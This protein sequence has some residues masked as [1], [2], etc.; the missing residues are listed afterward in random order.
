MI[1]TIN[2]YPVGGHYPKVDWGGGNFPS[3]VAVTRAS[4]G[5]AGSAGMHA[6]VPVDGSVLPKRIVWAEAVDNPPPDFDEMPV[7]NISGRARAVMEEIE[8]DT[9]Q[10]FPVDYVWP[11]GTQIETRYWLI[12]CN[13]LNAIDPLRSNLVMNQYNWYIPPKDAVRRKVPMPAHVDPAL[14]PKIVI[15]KSKADGRHFWREKHTDSGMALMSD[16]AWKAIQD[17]GLTGLRPQ[18]LEVS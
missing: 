3:P 4:D 6:G 10:F 1:Y 13:R 8:P 12:I 17:A 15:D 18:A 9:H 16:V 7:L 11:D 14:P 2:T 5:G